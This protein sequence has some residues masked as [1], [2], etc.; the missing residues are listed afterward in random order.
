MISFFSLSFSNIADCCPG[1]NTNC[2]IMGGSSSPET[3]FP[4]EAMYEK[5]PYPFG[6]DPVSLGCGWYCVHVDMGENKFK[7]GV[8]YVCWVAK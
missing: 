6:L 5:R 8:L 2:V 4:R 7:N 1:V 3:V